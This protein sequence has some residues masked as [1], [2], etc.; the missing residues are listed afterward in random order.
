MGNNKWER[1]HRLRV[2]EIRYLPDYHETMVH[3][4][5]SFGVLQ[6]GL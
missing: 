5:K 4:N 6:E 2:H 3:Y 1:Q